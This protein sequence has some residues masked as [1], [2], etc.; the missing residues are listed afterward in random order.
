M[1]ESYRRKPRIEKI[2]TGRADIGWPYRS[3]TISPAGCEQHSNKFPCAGGSSGSGWYF[4]LPEINP[5]SHMWQTPV[6]HDQR[7][8][9]SQASAKSSRLPNFGS[10]R[11]FN[12]LRAKEICGPVPAGPTGACGAACGASAI[13]GVMALLGPNISLCTR[14]SAT[15]HA[16]K[17]AV[18][19]SMNAAGP[20]K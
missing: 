19:S 9:T 4:T 13:P 17:P 18:R 6:R 20:H 2:K 12:P 5:L 1:I 10:H 3:S 8:G 14:A 7:T 11:A 16:F 15:P